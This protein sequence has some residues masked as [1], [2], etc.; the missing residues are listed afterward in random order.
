[1]KI[2]CNYVNVSEQ[3]GQ[4][5]S[6]ETSGRVDELDIEAIQQDQLERYQSR[7][8]TAEVIVRCYPHGL[9]APNPRSVLEEALRTQADD[10]GA[11]FVARY[12]ELYSEVEA[13]SRTFSDMM[14]Q[15]EKEF[16]NP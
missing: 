13:G 7:N 3:S 16:R 5:V 8:P 6:V 4:R 15:L 12:G 10:Q 14:E 11:R 2:T 1:M 9:Q